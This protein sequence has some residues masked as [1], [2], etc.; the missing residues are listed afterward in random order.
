MAAAQRQDAARNRERV[1]R[2]A[3]EFVDDGRP[4]Q[5]NEVARA[6]G[7]GIGTVYR[8]FPTPAVLL[9]E[10]ARPGLEELT[11]RAERS[12]DEDPWPGLARFL[13]AALE[14]LLS[15]SALQQV[16]SAPGEV[17]EE[18]SAALTALTA[19]ADRL[20]ARAVASGDVR[21]GITSADIAPLM[22]GV[23]YAAHARSGSE[24]S[25]AEAGH[26]Y[27]DIVLRGLCAKA[28]EG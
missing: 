13:E 3:R 19:Q 5:L 11:I 15:D 27:L 1:V 6:A 22:C 25:P 16:T 28:A 12:L 21:A 23:A 26:R 18:T 2:A 7:V 14:L 24:Q 4:L 17:S 10:L 8:Q 9:E 20:L